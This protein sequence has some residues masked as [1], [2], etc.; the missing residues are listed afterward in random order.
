MITRTLTAALAAAGMSFAAATPA[1]AQ[2]QGQSQVQIEPIDNAEL[3]ETQVEA[4]IDAATSIRAV[5]QDYQPRVQA[6]ESQ[7]QAADLQREAQGELVIA[8]EAAG[9]TPTEYQRIAAAAQSDPQVAQ[10]LQAEA[11]AR[12]QAE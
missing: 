11:E 5:I 1:L 2:A 8:V 6:A 7:E 9:L 10:R 12:M 3:T 4:F